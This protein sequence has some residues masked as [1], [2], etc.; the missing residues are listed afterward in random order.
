[1]LSLGILVPFPCFLD[2]IIK[3]YVNCLEG[4][5]NSKALKVLL[6]KTEVKISKIDKTKVLMTNGILMEHSA[7]LLAC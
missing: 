2:V 7:I 5:Q 3:V 4:L 1:M 6:E